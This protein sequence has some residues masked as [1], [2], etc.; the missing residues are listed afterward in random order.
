M[1]HQ[2]I[3]SGVLLPR[4]STVSHISSVGLSSGNRYGRGSKAS[5]LRSAALPWSHANRA[6]RRR[7]RETAESGPGHRARRNGRR[8][9]VQRQ[10]LTA[11]DARGQSAVA[12]SPRRQHRQ[13]E[14]PMPLLS[15]RFPSDKAS[16]M[17]FQKSTAIAQHSPYVLRQFHPRVASR[18]PSLSQLAPAA[19]ATTYFIIG[20]PST[21]EVAGFFGGQTQPWRLAPGTELEDDAV[22]GLA[23][24]GAK[25]RRVWG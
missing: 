21:A 11:P 14:T 1:A 9:K 15:L 7:D 16:P 13:P 6:S 19:P 23:C 22:T 17:I 4:N 12:R 3:P 20:W 18:C 25:R 24:E 10:K 8:I 5:G 2:L